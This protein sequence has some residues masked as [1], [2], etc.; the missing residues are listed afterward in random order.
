MLVRIERLGCRRCCAED[1]AIGRLGH[2][3]HAGQQAE[4]EV[5][6]VKINRSKAV[7]DPDD[8]DVF[9]RFEPLSQLP[10]PI[11]IA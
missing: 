11:A 5:V 8:M 4:V 10:R 2:R 7:F 9:A 1:H 3:L 6:V